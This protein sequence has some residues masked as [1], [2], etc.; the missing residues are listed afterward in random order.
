MFCFH[1]K[2]ANDFKF[3]KTQNGMNENLTFLNHLPEYNIPVNSSQVR[4]SIN[5]K[6]F[7]SNVKEKRFIL[8]F[9]HFESYTLK[10][11]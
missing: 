11:H 2:N 3:E 9:Q 4:H 10:G 1:L 6:D 8:N 5:T 7:F